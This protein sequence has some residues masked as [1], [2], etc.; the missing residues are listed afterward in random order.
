M[1]TFHGPLLGLQMQTFSGTF[2]ICVCAIMKQNVGFTF[3]NWY[4]WPW[5]LMSEEQ[6]LGRFLKKKITHGLGLNWHYCFLLTIWKRRPFLLQFLS[7]FHKSAIWDTNKSVT[8]FTIIFISLS[9]GNSFTIYEIAF[10]SLFLKQM[11]LLPLNACICIL[12]SPCFLLPRLYVVYYY[13]KRYQQSSFATGHT[14]VTVNCQEY[15]YL[16]PYMCM[17]IEIWIW[18]WQKI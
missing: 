11:L 12:I 15:L 4:L 16:V 1:M 8:L 14:V 17:Y 18:F 5:G 6:V 10:L 2:S 3:K 13:C 9:L 7:T